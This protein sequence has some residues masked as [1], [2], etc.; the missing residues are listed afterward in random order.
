[1]VENRWGGPLTVRALDTT[2]CK[3]LAEPDQPLLAC[4]T[5]GSNR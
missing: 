3:D 2:T 4:T 1:M 5:E